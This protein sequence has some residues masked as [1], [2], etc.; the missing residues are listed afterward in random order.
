MTLPP[1][2]L[3]S[4]AP[5]PDPVLS[6]YNFREVAPEVISP[7]A[8]SIIGWGM[9]RGF[10]QA[11]R[12]LGFPEPRS[13]RPHY[14]GY[15]AFRPF[16]NMT[17]IG[18]MASAL[19][20][21]AAADI[22]EMLLGGPP[23]TAGDVA[24]QG[25]RLRRAL[26]LPREAGFFE[27][28]GDRFGTTA[29]A[30][31]DA[32]ALVD[33]ALGRGSH[34][35][36]SA[37]FDT[38]VTAGRMAWALHIRTTCVALM[39]AAVLRRAL[40]LRVDDAS[41]LALVRAAAQRSDEGR[42]GSD[43]AGRLRTGLDRITSYEVADRTPR[44]ARFADNAA[45]PPPTLMNPRAPAPAEDVNLLTGTALGPLFERLGRSLEVALGERERSKALGLRALHGVRLLLDSGHT[46]I[47]PDDAALLSVDE[48]RRASLPQLER[49]VAQRAGELDAAAALEV[50]VDL[51]Q[52]PRG[53]VALRRPIGS[54]GGSTGVPLA[55]G[56][57][58]GVLCTESDGA[59]GRVLVGT[60]V[61]GNYVLATEPEGVVSKF[62]SILSHVA[63]VCR[64]LGI[65]LVSGVEIR[66]EQI[67]QRAVVD[68]W[69]GTI[70]EVP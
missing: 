7:L 55:A 6:G 15:L 53:A 29:A 9:D 12:E 67:G 30:V 14:V 2:S 62:G 58:E 57:A 8:W 48:L 5:V 36:T 60:R 40:R 61:D 25:S 33:A 3:D 59:K 10:R 23:P 27:A 52:Q 68:G 18:A 46:G 20:G 47:D 39:A 35:T 69:A 37:A 26:R 64:E 32:E 13:G 43:E 50:P 1:F 51:Q 16:F 41:A 24:P 38:A 54:G 28:N 19:P 49:L 11:A 56:W 4:P 66:P 70:T 42:H 65:P 21:V 63:I 44:F 31:D 22:W 17:T 34:L 45:S